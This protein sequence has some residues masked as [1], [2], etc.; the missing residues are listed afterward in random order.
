M[1]Y[2][3]P[4]YIATVVIVAAGGIP[5]GSSR[6]R[7]YV[8]SLLTHAGYDEGGFSASITLPSFVKDFGLTPSLWKHDASGLASRTADITSF[9]VLG[10]ALGAL[11]ALA[12]ADR[13]G[14]LRCWQFFVTL[15]ASGL[16][17]QI[18]S[19]GILGFLFFARIWGGFGAGGL[20][21]VAPLYLS[22]IAPA[23]SRGM[24]ISIFMVLLLSFL[25]LGKWP[26][27][28]NLA[29]KNLTQLQASL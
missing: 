27:A 19:S 28:S 16:L 18:F 24:I 8:F 20:T 23:K 10:A 13:F 1:P 11:I 17:M 29:F 12:M 9:G 2:F 5:K 3:N 15:W 14:R 22:E 26:A 6:S 7:S 21:V 4:Y 25:S